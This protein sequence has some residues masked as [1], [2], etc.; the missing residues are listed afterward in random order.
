MVKL[1]KSSLQLLLMTCILI[2][3]QVI[4]VEDG[5]PDDPEG[6]NGGC[7]RIMDCLVDI[8]HPREITPWTVCTRLI[9]PIVGIAFKIYQNCFWPPLEACLECN[10]TWINLSASNVPSYEC[11]HLSSAL[12]TSISHEW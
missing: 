6:L 10:G 1:L 12:H 11:Y 8:R 9:V 3:S 4:A 2:S 7:R 5:L